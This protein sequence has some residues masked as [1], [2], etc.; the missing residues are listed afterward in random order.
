[1]EFVEFAGDCLPGVGALLLWG[2]AAIVA[3]ALFKAAFKAL[4]WITD[5]VLQLTG[6]AYAGER[7]PLSIPYVG[8]VVLQGLTV[9]NPS[10][11]FH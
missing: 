7:P 6:R 8:N 9:T 4:E 3:C 11:T 10:K 2:L 1:M 5:R